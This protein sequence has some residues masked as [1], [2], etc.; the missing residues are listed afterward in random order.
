[1]AN[2]QGTRPT[3]P[4]LDAEPC[5]LSAWLDAQRLSSGGVSPSVQAI[6]TLHQQV[7]AL[8]KEIYNA[9]AGG[10]KQDGLGL[11]RQLRYLH[12]RCMIRL[13]PFTHISSRRSA[14]NITTR[15]GAAPSDSDAA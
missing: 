15:H 2:L 12:E 14:G 8:A 6:E 11:L 9:R 1:L 3:T 13:Q 5:S 7:H 10:R 4:P